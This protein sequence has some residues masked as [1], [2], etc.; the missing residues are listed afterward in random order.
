MHAAFLGRFEVNRLKSDDRY[1]SLIL[2][3]LMCFGLDNRMRIGSSFAFNSNWLEFIYDFDGVRTISMR[4]SCLR[5]RQWLQWENYLLSS[6]HGNKSRS[7][8]ESISNLHMGIFIQW[9]ICAAQLSSD[10]SPF[11]HTRQAPGRPAMHRSLIRVL[12]RDCR[13]LQAYLK[14]ARITAYMQYMSVSY[15]Y[16]WSMYSILGIF[17][18][19]RR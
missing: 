11:T 10:G 2:D 16:K 17:Q 4:L 7:V 19:A 3:T 5:P 12:V 15:I 18:W 14:Q 8:K 9:M 6:A 1:R 13:P